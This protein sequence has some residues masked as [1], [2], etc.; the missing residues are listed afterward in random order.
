MK[1]KIVFIF[2]LIL[3]FSSSVLATGPEKQLKIGLVA[4]MTGA[5]AP[6]GLA[7]KKGAQLIAEQINAAGGITVQGQI[8]KI[9]IIAEDDKYNPS[10]AVTVTNKLIF[11]DKVGFIL[12]P[13]GSALC[14]AMSPITEANKVIT[15]HSCQTPKSLGP[16]LPFTFRA[17]PLIG[18]N[19][20][21]MFKWIKG[22][23]PKVKKLAVLS[24]NDE[25][26]WSVNAEYMW[27]GRKF[28]FE[29]VAEDYFQRNTNDFYPVLTRI[30]KNQPDLLAMSG[31]TGDIA[32]I[33]KQA[34]Q[35][36]YKGLAYSSAGHDA[37]KL[38]KVAGKEYAEGYLHS[39][40]AI[41]PGPI[42]KWHDEYV[43][44]WGEWGEASVLGTALDII[45]QG[46]KKANSLDTIK[47]REAI[48]KMNYNDRLYGPLKF[49][50]KIGRAH[51]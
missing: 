26:G 40:L 37:D 19:V 7:W 2:A 30:L 3:C 11:D 49:G 18:E 43:T 25:T 9:E 32:L 8:Y 38:C 36:G 44:R 31:G 15:F 21:P 16:E 34:R 22:K 46:I 13:I 45:I 23:Y 6:W 42:K 47:V 51:V 27:V 20:P 4:P 50:G 10:E 35:M 29:T 41:I 17:I 39:A 5:G 24:P 28:G 1:K 48:E 14:M 33:L 12:G